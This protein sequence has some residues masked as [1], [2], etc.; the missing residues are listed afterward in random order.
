MTGHFTGTGDG[1]QACQAPGVAVIR[2]WESFRS[3]SRAFL[4]WEYR[5]FS[6]CAGPFF[7]L[8]ELLSKPAE[9]GTLLLGSLFQQFH[10]APPVVVPNSRQN[11]IHTTH[12][13][14]G[15]GAK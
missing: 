7:L 12:W 5:P 3:G 6:S 15:G 11:A 1:A 10:V 8:Q 13:R 9:T 14:S 4:K 2:A